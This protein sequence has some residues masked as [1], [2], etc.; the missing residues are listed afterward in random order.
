VLHCCSGGT[1]NFHDPYTASWSA[2]AASASTGG[3]PICATVR[4]THRCDGVRVRGQLPDAR[5]R[6]RVPQPHRLIE[7]AT[8]LLSTGAAAIMAW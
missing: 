2:S 7:A 8:D 3:T 6:P 4:K 1:G 5:P